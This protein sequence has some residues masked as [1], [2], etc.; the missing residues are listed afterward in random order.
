MKL[1]K[2]FFKESTEPQRQGSF[3]VP[4]T[5]A[6]YNFI[7]ENSFKNKNTP[8]IEQQEVISPGQFNVRNSSAIDFFKNR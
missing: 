7:I 6:K 4:K 3:S 5:S 8:Q 2:T 1:N